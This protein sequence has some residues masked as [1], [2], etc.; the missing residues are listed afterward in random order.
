MPIVQ[1]AFL[2]SLRLLSR[3]GDTPRPEG[4][5]AEAFLQ[6][7]PMLLEEVEDRAFRSREEVARMGY[8]LRTFRFVELLGLAE[9]MDGPDRRLV[10]DSE[11]LV[12]KRPLLDA[13]IRFCV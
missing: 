5:Y 8:A 12:R 13:W 9:R 3:Y 4:F 2:F 10:H 1:E 7:F 6:A 11:A